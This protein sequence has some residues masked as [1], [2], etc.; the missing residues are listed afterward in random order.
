[1]LPRHNNDLSGSAFLHASAW[2]GEMCITHKS[3]TN[4]FTQ[5]WHEHECG[6]IDF[7]LAGGGV[8]TY[9]S[10]EVRSS[11]G[12][13]E[14]FREELRHKFTSDGNGIRS[15]HVVLPRTTLDEAFG[16]NRVAVEELEHSR[17]IGLAAGIY[18]E[19]TTPD[20]SSELAMESLVYELLDEVRS[21]ARKGRCRAGWLGVVRDAIHDLHDRPLSLEELSKIAGVSRGHLV[22]GFRT[23]VG[24]TPGEYHR[25]V[26][27]NRSARML[28]DERTSIARIATEAGFVDQAHLSNAFKKFTGM[29]PNEFRSVVC[30]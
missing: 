2:V 23:A 3:Y 14:F 4:D 30:A 1:M 21:V 28:A 10:R 26:R 20:R 15:M 5:R 29:T 16:T 18:R 12:L 27:L 22:R 25:R 13:V 24:I 7:I 9:G 19:L 8:G 17:A 11:P 6:S